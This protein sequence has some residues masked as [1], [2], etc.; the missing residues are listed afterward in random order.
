MNFKNINPPKIKETLSIGLVLVTLTTPVLAKEYKIQKGD[1][2]SKISLNEY[3]KTHYYD[4]LA[5]YNYIDNPDI[6]KVGQVIELPPLQSLLNY[7]YDEIYTVKKGDTLGK[8][9]KE[10]YGST[11]FTKALALYNDI[12]NI[13][14]NEDELVSLLNNV[15]LSG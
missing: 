15:P 12:E 1:T 9:C 6:I 5:Y 11:R 13:N 3:G 2:L 7:T 4:E 8:L 14:L 10:K